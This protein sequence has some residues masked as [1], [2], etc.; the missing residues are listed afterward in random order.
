MGGLISYHHIFMMQSTFVIIIIIITL[1]LAFLLGLLSYPISELF[2]HGQYR[3]HNYYCNCRKLCLLK[4]SIKSG[5]LIAFKVAG[6]C[7][8]FWKTGSDTFRSVLI[9]G[10]E[11]EFR[12]KIFHNRG[13]NASF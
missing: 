2:L 3:Y 9:C 13:K 6:S 4:Y 8:I 7:G 5:Q 12:K 10:K 11:Q 1:R